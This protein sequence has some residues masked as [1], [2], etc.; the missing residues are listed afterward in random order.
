MNK[1]IILSISVLLV[2][3]FLIITIYNIYLNK[4]EHFSNDDNSTTLENDLQKTLNSLQD[5]IKDYSNRNIEIVNE[6]ILEYTDKLNRVTKEWNENN[7]I[8]SEC[9]FDESIELNNYKVVKDKVCK[10]E[11]DCIIHVIINIIIIYIYV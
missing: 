4:R 9:V 8:D 11:L 5:E 3:I 6:K 10:F 1:N 2:I 7:N